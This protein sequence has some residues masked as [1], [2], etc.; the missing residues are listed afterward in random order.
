MSRE[1]LIAYLGWSA[2]DVRH[3]IRL[4]ELNKIPG[5]FEEYL[6][7]LSEL[8]RRVEKAAVRAVLRRHRQRHE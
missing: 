5:A 1:D 4:A 2:S 3:A 8:D 6:E 7:R